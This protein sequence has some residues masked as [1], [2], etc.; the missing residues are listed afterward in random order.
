MTLNRITDN[1]TRKIHETSNSLIQKLIHINNAKYDSAARKRE[2]P[3]TFGKNVL[4]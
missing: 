3:H 1:V 2:A 4:T